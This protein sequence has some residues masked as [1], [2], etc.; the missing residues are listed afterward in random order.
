MCIRDSHQLLHG[1]AAAHPRRSGR[2]EHRGFHD[3][4]RSFRL[5]CGRYLGSGFH[6]DPRHGEGRLPAGKMCIRDRSSPV[7]YNAEDGG[8]TDLLFAI[9]AP[10]NGSLHV[11]MLAR[12]RCV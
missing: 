6:P 5:L 3:L 2:S 10:E 4:W 12:M 11:D 7:Q 8:T 1:A 9:A